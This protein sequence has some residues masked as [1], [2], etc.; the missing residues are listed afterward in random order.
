M[1][2][3]LTAVSDPAALIGAS[4]PVTGRPD[5]DDVRFTAVL[6]GPEHAIG[7]YHQ[8][9][10]LVTVEIGGGNVRTGRLVGTVDE[11]G[12]LTASYCMVLADGEVIAG[13]CL[14]TPSLLPD[15]RL[16]L[17]EQWRRIDGSAGTSHIASLAPVADPAGP[18]ATSSTSAEPTSAADGSSSRT[19]VVTPRPVGEKES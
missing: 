3:S 2:E 8:D 7:H 15:G 10:D 13:S 11:A 18:P 6:P 16:L 17:T 14:S 12:V 9:G 19:P 5:Y 4:R 1:T